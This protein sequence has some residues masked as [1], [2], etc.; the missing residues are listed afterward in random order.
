MKQYNIPAL[1]FLKVKSVCCNALSRA[2]LKLICL[3]KTFK[4]YTDA[5]YN[6]VAYMFYLTKKLLLGYRYKI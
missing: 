2:I 1:K 4:L 6:D 5:A 3:G